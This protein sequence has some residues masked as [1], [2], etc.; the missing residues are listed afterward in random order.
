ML[1]IS[2]LFLESIVVQSHGRRA[3][4][5]SLSY[6]MVVDVDIKDL[7]AG[8]LASARPTIA[9]VSRRP[10]MPLR[11][12]I[13]LN[14]AALH[15]GSLL[16]LVQFNN[17]VA[18]KLIPVVIH[19]MLHGLGIASMNT[20]YEAVGWNQFLDATKTWYAGPNG[21][22]TKSKAIAAYREIVGS[23]VTRIPVENSFGAGSAYSHWEEGLKDGFVREPRYY[24]YGATGGGKVFHPAL[25][26]EVMTS[27]AG[28]RF[29]FTKMTAG[30]LEDHGYVVNGS[31]PNI[32]AYP[33]ALLQKL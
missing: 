32:V 20:P 30:A 11:Q 3:S 33:K 13:I 14:R 9:D 23:Q 8:I 27:V 6:D 10:A 29:Y 17:T 15:T 7:S 16:S 28:S 31:S 2:K 5:V 4:S 25:P 19:E 22:W 18:P 26:E 24:D 1:L 21:D 12:S